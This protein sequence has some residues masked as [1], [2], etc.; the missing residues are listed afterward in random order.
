MMG[1][2]LVLLRKVFVQD[3]SNLLFLPLAHGTTMTYAIISALA[4]YI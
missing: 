1:C 3:Y 4:F 2:H